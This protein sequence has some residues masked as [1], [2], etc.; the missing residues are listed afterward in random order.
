MVIICESDGLLF[1]WSRVRTAA[2]W[3]SLSPLKRPQLCSQVNMNTWYRT[4]LYTSSTPY[5]LD[6][7]TATVVLLICKSLWI[8]A[9]AKWCNVTVGG[10]DHEMFIQLLCVCW[11]AGGSPH[12]DLPQGQMD[13][14]L[15]I[16]SSQRERFRLRNQELEAVSTH[17]VTL[18]GSCRSEEEADCSCC[19]ASG[20][21]LPTA[22]LTGSSERAGQS[23]GRQHQAVREDQVPAELP[24]QSKSRH[25]R[26]LNQMKSELTKSIFALQKWH[27][28]CVWSSI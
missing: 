17:H 18:T 6:G 24:Y 14:L 13:S 9:S 15:S 20:E 7:L 25:Y 21:Q 4:L 1:L 16:I 8:K 23:A 5:W 22:D 12:A 2:R 11:G 28:S 27:R 10:A 3:S 26:A 19:C